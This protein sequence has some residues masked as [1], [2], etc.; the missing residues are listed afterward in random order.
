[1]KKDLELHQFYMQCF[2]S[3]IFVA[4]CI[5]KLSVLPEKGKPNESLYWGGLLSTI[6]WWLPS[7]GSRKQ[8]NNTVAVESEETYIDAGSPDKS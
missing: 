4:F 8:S 3:S 5:F 2:F 7:P 1:M 6:S